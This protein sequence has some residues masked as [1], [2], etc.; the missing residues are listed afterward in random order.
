MAEE[1]TLDGP[2]TLNLEDVKDEPVNE[3]WHLVEIEKAEPKRTNQ[4]KLPAVFVVARIV[5]EEDEDFNRTLIWNN[6]LDPSSQAIRF[7]KRCFEAL[8]MPAELQ[9]EN[10]VQGLCEDL[11]GRRVDAKAKHETYEGDVRARVNK[12][13]QPELGIEL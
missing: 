11:I 12:W 10:G 1:I 3:G 7:T 9:Y 13:R 4:K 8:G 5:D 6:I 2:F